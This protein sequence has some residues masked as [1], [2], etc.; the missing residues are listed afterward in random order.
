LPQGLAIL[1]ASLLSKTVTVLTDVFLDDKKPP[2]GGPAWIETAWAWFSFVT[3][4]LAVMWSA[5]AFWF[6]KKLGA[7]AGHPIGRGVVLK[8]SASDS[9]RWHC[10]L[11]LLYSLLA[12]SSSSSVVMAACMGL[13]LQ[14]CLPI[15]I[16]HERRRGHWTL[17]KPCCV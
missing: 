13:C 1:K 3:F 4:Q 8:S 12:S 2:A 6:R 5:P 9:C 17:Y 15:K 14:W 11:P 16:C 7:P 10:L